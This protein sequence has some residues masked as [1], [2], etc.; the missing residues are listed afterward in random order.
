MP[1]SPIPP[2]VL[3]VLPY[4][5]ARGAQRYARALVDALNAEGESHQILTLF[6]ADPVLLRPDVEL[7]VPRGLF[8]RLGLD[9]RVVRRLRSEVKRISPAVVVAH[10]GESAKYAAIALPPR[11]APRVSEDRHSPSSASAEGEPFPPRLLHPTGRRCRRG[12]QRRGR[13]GQPA[14]RRATGS[15]RGHPE[16]PGPG[17]LADSHRRQGRP[18]GRHL[19]GPSRSR[20]AP[21]LVHRCGRGAERR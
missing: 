11:S 12:V 1:G 3:H 21:G 20:K 14:L 17:R 16:R 15:S 7:D 18:A 4:D 5:L 8:R 6:R 10:G 19:R 9:P 13:G 2:V